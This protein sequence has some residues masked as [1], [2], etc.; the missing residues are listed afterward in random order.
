[1]SAMPRP[2][3]DITPEHFF[4][5]WLPDQLAA[6]PQKPAASMTVRIKLDGEGGG[7]WDVAM[8]P[9]GV[10]VDPAGTAEP[11]VTLL[12][13]VAD[14]KAIAVGEH[15]AVDLAPAQA[16]PTD[17]LFFEPQAQQLLSTVK[18]TVRFE[19]T[20]FNG[21][22]WSLTVKFGTQPLAPAPDATIS[23]D[24]E[25]YAGMLARTIPPAQA[26][27]QGKITLAGDTGLAMQLGMAMM[28][29]MQ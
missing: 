7:A 25:T 18:G 22:T 20:G 4:R 26:F 8:T 23:V 14:W 10:S 15:G 29:R 2:P 24:A 12:Q 11:E 9:A 13:T 21:R 28:P 5:S 19:V 16:S 1:M 17:M 27:F 6:L 3:K